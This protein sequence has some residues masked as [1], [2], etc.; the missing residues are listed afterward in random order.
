MTDAERIKEIVRLQAELN[1]V[2]KETA[3]KVE[4]IK[5]KINELCGIS[6]GATRKKSRMTS[7][8]WVSAGR[9]ITGGRR[10]CVAQG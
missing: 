9:A 3:A 5:A 4:V 8:Q 1:Q 10:E 6:T 7:N 2:E